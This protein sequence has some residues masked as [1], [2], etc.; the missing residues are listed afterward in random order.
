M[1]GKS[2]FR[3]VASAAAV[4][5][6]A[7]LLASTAGVRGVAASTA[8]GSAARVPSHCKVAIVGGGIGGAYTAWRLVVDAK[9]V[10]GRD[11]CLFEAAQRFGGRILTVSDVP[12]FEGYTVDLG[13]YRYHRTHHTH[14][15]S[16]VEGG[17]KLPVHCYTDPLNRDDGVC[18]PESRWLVTSRGARWQSTNFT[19]DTVDEQLASWSPA[20]PFAIPRKYRWGK[21]QPLDE[22]RKPADFLL[23]AKSGVPAVAA[24]WEELQRT[25]DYGRAMKIVDEVLAAVRADSYRGTPW[26]EVSLTTLATEQGG[27]TREE[28]SYFLQT[29]ETIGDNLFLGPTSVYWLL[30][31][32]LRRVALAKA[33]ID[34][35]K[36]MV[37]PVKDDAAKTRAG[38][39]TIIHTMLDAAAKAGVRIYK[40]HKVD[41]ITRADGGG[42]KRLRLA[43]ANG[44]TVTTDRAF[45]NMGHPDVVS[46]GR[47]SLPLAEASATFTR[48]VE[49]T[50]PYALSKMYC[51]WHDAWWLSALRETVGRTRT[52]FPIASARFHD[53]AMRCRD[54]R[55]LSGCSGSMLVSYSLS[56]DVLGS[57][58]ALPPSLHDPTP[59]SP[60]SDADQGRL[61]LAGRLTPRQRLLYDAVL[62]QLRA[63]YNPALAAAGVRRGVPPPA[64]CVAASWTHV[65]V[66]IRLPYAAADGGA[67]RAAAAA[68]ED[69]LAAAVRPVPG[70]DI[71]MV[72]EAWGVQH[73]WAEAS[74]SAAELAL[75]HAMRLGRPPW[76]DAPFHRSTIVQMNA[77]E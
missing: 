61:L 34:G 68:A 59:Y 77:G 55:T 60:L 52:D 13:A 63:L 18:K 8:D 10:A 23:S 47:T 17:L 53:G 74:V 75:H 39:V 25:S 56:D 33:R 58:S 32:R 29:D 64:A 20:I 51:F 16:L 41:R 62:R 11:V 19:T 42:G 6:A 76:M 14:M 36:A 48:S 37:V 69:P 45:L 1:T 49:A 9:A 54:R 67:G 3:G 44:A 7:A 15:R 72:N 38:M 5:A 57:S 73:G 31:D 70:L 24:R 46:L 28:L 50:L 40:G 66:H 26:S 27:L 65:G 30:R 22:R 2:I 71:H 43:F 21:G 12:G 4:A 35:F